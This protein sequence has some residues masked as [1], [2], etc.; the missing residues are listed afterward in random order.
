LG[1]KSHEFQV[2]PMTLMSRGRT[3]IYNALFKE[4]YI[5]GLN[6]IYSIYLYCIYVWIIIFLCISSFSF[7]TNPTNFL[8]GLSN[9]ILRKIQP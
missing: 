5:L 8:K 3:L 7:K 6:T 4:L 1:C 9:I 2:N